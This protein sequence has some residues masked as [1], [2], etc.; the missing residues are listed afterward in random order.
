M[1][2][3]SG[4]RPVTTLP[5]EGRDKLNWPSTGHGAVTR[6]EGG[7]NRSDGADSESVAVERYG[8][9]EAFELVAHET[10]LRTLEVLNGEDGPLT[11]SDLQERVGVRDSGRF[12]YH[13]G[14][15]TGRFVRR[16]ED[17]YRLSPA[18]RRVVG[19]VLSGGYTHELEGDSVP[20]DGTCSD[21]DGRLEARF[22]EVKLRIRCSDCGFVHTEPRIPPGMFEHWQR[23]DAPAVVDR[24]MKRIQI[25]AAYGFCYNCDGRIDRTVAL[26]GEEA[27]PDWFSGDL[28]EATGVWRCRRCGHWWHSI[29]PAAIP[30]HPAV[31]AFHHEH[32]VDVRETPTWNLDWISPGLATVTDESPLRVAVP[33]TLGDET[34]VFVFDRDLDLVEER[35]G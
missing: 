31:T 32:G 5:L 34:R 13:L 9:T 23:E 2:P 8:P 33:V 7:S 20:V 29:L 10:R 1:T 18:G 24:W 25:D 28:A 11:F 15:L 4:G 21:C 35:D 14:K 6:D 3:S 19:A 30:V 12:N 26:P 22:H 27:A 17:G 16:V